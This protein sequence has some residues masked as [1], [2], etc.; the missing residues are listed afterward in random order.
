MKPRDFTPE[1]WGVF[2]IES[3]WKFYIFFL[4]MYLIWKVKSIKSF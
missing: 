4:Y 2:S 1:Q 3:K